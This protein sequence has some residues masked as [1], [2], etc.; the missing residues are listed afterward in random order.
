MRNS[1]KN[2]WQEW[3]LENQDR[4]LLYARQ[5][6]RSEADAQDVLQESIV[7]IWQES[8]PSESAE[9][10]HPGSVY[11]AIRFRALNL[12]RGSDRRTRRE[13]DYMDLNYVGGPESSPYAAE[14]QKLLLQ[15][16][17]SLPSTLG[18]VLTLHVWGE[19]TFQEIADVCKCS[20]NTIAG[21]YRQA[22][23]RLQKE[24]KGTFSL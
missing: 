21:R 16:V 17:Q 11:A 9:L 2:R 24:L 10:P 4:W 12:A 15:A 5:Q 7:S 20:I 3:I 13:Q 22:L 14:E 18:E 6:T 23:I 19:L 8:D 1:E